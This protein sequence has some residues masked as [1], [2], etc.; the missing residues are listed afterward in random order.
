M[1]PRYASARRITPDYVPFGQATYVDGTWASSIAYR[2]IPL[3]TFTSKS[4]V[5]IERY[6]AYCPA[7]GHGWLCMFF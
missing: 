1:V 3:S 6:K 2:R 4:A 7:C 5:S